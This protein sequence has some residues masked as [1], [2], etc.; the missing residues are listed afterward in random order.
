MHME[1]DPDEESDLLH[2]DNTSFRVW[3]LVCLEK[4]N[5]NPLSCEPGLYKKPIVRSPWVQALLLAYDLEYD[6]FDTQKLDDGFFEAYPCL[7]ADT[8]TSKWRVKNFPGVGQIDVGRPVEL[9]RQAVFRM[10]SKIESLVGAEIE[11]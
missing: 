10:K 7:Y 5:S 1:L 8:A 11:I 6:E 3:D 2:D 4:D 9:T